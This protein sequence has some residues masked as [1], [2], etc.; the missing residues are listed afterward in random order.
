MGDFKE[1]KSEAI[2]KK[3]EE[4]MN[5]MLKANTMDYPMCISFFALA[6]VALAEAGAIA[7][8]NEE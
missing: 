2:K 4:A 8:K 5:L 6:A 1:R 3:H 7:A